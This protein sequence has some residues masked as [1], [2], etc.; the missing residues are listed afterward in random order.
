MPE[1]SSPASRRRLEPHWRP[2]RCEQTT[3][4]GLAS[5]LRGW[6]AKPF[7][8]CQPQ[9]VRSRG[10]SDRDATN[11]PNPRRA[12]CRAISRRGRGGPCKVR[13]RAPP[14]AP[15][16]RRSRPHPSGAP[17]MR[18]AHRNSARAMRPALQTRP[19]TVFEIMGRAGELSARRSISRASTASAAAAIVAC[20]TRHRVP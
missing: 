8:V 1:L 10:F 12:D 6:L 15:P 18:R 5:K 20:E 11:R 16:S 7:T 2:L 13:R 19:Q 9:K 3:T 17:G 4:V 14:P